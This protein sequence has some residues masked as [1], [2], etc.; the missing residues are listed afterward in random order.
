MYTMDQFFLLIYQWRSLSE[1]YR[2]FLAW[3]YISRMKDGTE[4]KL[5]LF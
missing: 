3:V 2:L 5:V 4:I 1:A